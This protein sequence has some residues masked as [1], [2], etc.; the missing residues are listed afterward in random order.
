MNLDP[1]ARVPESYGS[2]QATLLND[3][4]RRPA[5]RSNVAERPESNEQGSSHETNTD[6]QQLESAVDAANDKLARV[7]RRMEMYL[8][9]GTHEVAARI[10]DTQTDEVVKYI[11][12][13]ELLDL[14][15]RLD[16]MAGLL[17]DEGA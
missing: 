1:I 14:R 4:Q 3:N 9:E 11:P 5:V 8:V 2:A 13:R 16:E 15:S 7:N 12:S 17:F 6:V 10:V